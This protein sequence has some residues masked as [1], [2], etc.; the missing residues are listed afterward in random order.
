[1][2]RYLYSG[3]LRDIKRVDTDVVIVGCGAAGLYSALSLDPSIRCIILNK[4]DAK[5]S[6]SMYA[7]G[8]IAAVIEPNPQQDDPDKHYA[9]TLTAGAGLCDKKAVRVLVNEAWSDIEHL[10]ELGVP[11]DRQSGSLLLTREGGHGRNRILHCGGDATGLHLTDSLHEAAVKRDNISIMD[12]MFLTDIMTDKDGVTGVLTLDRDNIPCYFSASRVI[13]AS[14]GIGRIY[15][16]STNAV[17]ATGD[18]IAAAARAGAV[19]KDMEFIQFHPTAFTHPNEEGRFFLISEALRGEGAIL[20]NRRGEAFM[21]GVHPLADLAPRDIVTRAIISEMKKYDIPNVY[22][23]ITT[24]SRDFLKNRFPT[25][26]AE[27]MVRCVD[28]AKDWIPVMPV[29]HYFMGGIATDLDGQT[30]IPGLYACG[31]ASCTGVHGANRLASNS[32]LECLVFGRRCSSHINRSSLRVVGP[33]ALGVSPGAVKD[34]LAADDAVD[35]SDT[36]NA[37][38]AVDFESYISEIRTLITRKC[39][40]IRSGRELLEAEVRIQE[41]FSTLDSCTLK[42]PLAFEAYNQSQIALAVL[43][44]SIL[45]KTSVGAHYRCEDENEGGNHHADQLLP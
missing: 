11:F 16:N 17:G 23:D 39:G 19:L 26:Y 9:D 30:N 34:Y 8:G 2:R 44:A 29:Q 37:D 1:M 6:N 25:I 31:E 22:L 4:I 10:I 12:R 43:R 45:R 18:G 24:K 35:V 42:S 3:S 13:I 28:I 27:C 40:I 14:G 36:C 33:T 21:Q 41:I 15:R 7:Q 20:R 32:L 5:H 38:D